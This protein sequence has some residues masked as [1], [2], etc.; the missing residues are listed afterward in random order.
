MPPIRSTVTRRCPAKTMSRTIFIFRMS[1][2]RRSK[3]RVVYPLAGWKNQAAYTVCRLMLNVDRNF[4]TD[5]FSSAP[6]GL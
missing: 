5:L 6:T 3:Q 4:D 1:A 2:G